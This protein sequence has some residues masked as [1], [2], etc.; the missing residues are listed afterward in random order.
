MDVLLD[1]NIGKIEIEMNA[2]NPS[3]LHT[4]NM[5]YICDTY[6]HYTMVGEDYLEDVRIIQINF[7]YGLKNEK[8]IVRKYYMQDKTEKKYVKNMMIIEYNMD[9]IKNIWYSKNEKEIE[10]YRY[11]IMLDL[12]PVELEKLGKKDRLVKEYKMIVEMVNNDPNFK[13]RISE[14]E[15]R[16]KCFNSEISLAEKRG[17]N[18]GLQKGKN[19]QAIETAKNL[20]L[21][22]ISSDII[23]KC[24]RI[25]IEEIEKLKEAE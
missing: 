8:E 6:S 14:E 15:D 1:T 23:S 18:K 9:R 20:I 3:Y 4:R 19:E 25:S 5:A 10:K 21:E 11:L 7:T 16:R 24:T 22:G 2:T 12:E 17:I 13:R